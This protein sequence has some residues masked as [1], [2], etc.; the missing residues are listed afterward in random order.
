VA[1]YKLPNCLR[2]SIGDETACQ[3]VAEAVGQFK[4]AAS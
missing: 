1:G 4:G 3:R 2:I